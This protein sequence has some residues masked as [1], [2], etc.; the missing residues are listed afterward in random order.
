MQL[1]MLSV[2][3]KAFVCDL[4]MYTLN[5]KNPIWYHIFRGLFWQHNFKYLLYITYNGSKPCSNIIKY[6]QISRQQRNTLGTVRI[7]IKRSIIPKHGPDDKKYGFP[8]TVYT[9]VVQKKRNKC[10]SFPMY[11]VDIFVFMFNYNGGKQSKCFIKYKNK[12]HPISLQQ[13]NTF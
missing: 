8:W 10:S 9:M 2:M 3:E 13:R 1:S 11:F 6:K 5:W 4:K 12:Y 7:D